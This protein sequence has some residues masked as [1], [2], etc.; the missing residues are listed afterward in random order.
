MGGSEPIG[1]RIV[2]KIVKRT[3]FSKISTICPCG[4]HLESNH[5]GHRRLDVSPQRLNVVQEGSRVP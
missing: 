2:Y 1:R 4:H 3:G 5:A